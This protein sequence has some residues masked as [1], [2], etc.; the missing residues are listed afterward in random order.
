MKKFRIIHQQNGQQV[1]D[2]NQ[3]IKIFLGENIT[4]IKVC[5][6]YL[7]FDMNIR[8][9]DNTN[10]VVADDKTKEVIQLVNYAF[11]YTSHDARISTSSGTE[12]KQ[13]KFVGLI[14]I[15]MRLVPLKD[16]DLSTYFDILDESDNGIDNSSLKQILNNNHTEAN[17][18][19]IR[20]YLPLKKIFGFCRPFKKRTK[21]LGLAPHLTISNRK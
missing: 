11:S 15:N 16:R 8:K 5:C 10:F 2:G 17:G 4:F 6:G 3:A 12:N 21:G 19:V 1:N 13:I 20:G 7:E 18:E 9:P 14:S